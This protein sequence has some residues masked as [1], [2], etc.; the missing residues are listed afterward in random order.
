MTPIEKLADDLGQIVFRL[1]CHN[2][3][4][5]G[6]KDGYVSDLSELIQ[7]DLEKL[8]TIKTK[9]LDLEPNED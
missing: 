2:S 9:M 8:K 6:N 1:E 7:K 3:R 4:M 5:Y